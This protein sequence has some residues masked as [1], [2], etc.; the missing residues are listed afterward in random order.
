MG[1]R[2]NDHVVLLGGGFRVVVEVVYHESVAIGRE[3]NIEFDEERD[4]IAWRRSVR[5]ERKEDVAFGIDEFEKG[6]G[7]QCRT[8]GF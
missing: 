2:H 7:F 4:S 6:F 5:R 8:V 3:V 1:R